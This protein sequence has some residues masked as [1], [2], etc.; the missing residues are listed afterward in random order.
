MYKENKVENTGLHIF[1][2]CQQPQTDLAY[3]SAIS[4]S[5]K[6]YIYLLFIAFFVIVYHW[7]RSVGEKSWK[8]NEKK[9]VKNWSYKEAQIQNNK[10]HPAKLPTRS[11]IRAW[12]VSL[13][14]SA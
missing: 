5:E 9:A 4:C 12:H 14:F 6:P 8:P 10:L 2:L 1:S 13:I 11:S 3:V 7:V